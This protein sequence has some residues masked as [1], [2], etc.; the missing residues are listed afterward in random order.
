M[1]DS[2][3]DPGLALIGAYELTQTAFS[4]LG[5]DAVIGA[6]CSGAS[7]TAAEYLQI[8]KTPQLSPASTSAALSDSAAYPYLARTPPSDAWQSFALADVVE[9][10]LG[11]ERLATV[12][13][14]DTFGASGMQQFKTSATRRGLKVLASTSFAN[15]QEDLSSSVEVLRRSGA[16]VVVLFCQTEDASRFIQAMQAAGAHNIT[17]VGPGAVTLAVRAMV[18][19]SPEQ[20]ARLRGFVGTGQSGGEGE[21]Y[22]AFRARLNAFQATIFNEGW[23]SNATDDDGRLL[24]ATADGGCPWAGADASADFYAPFAYDAVYA[25]A[26]AMSRT[27]AAANA[28]LID[29]ETLLAQLLNLTFRGASGL[30]GFDEHGDRDVG[31]SY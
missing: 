6:S 23:C 12:N 8:Y 17:Y 20:E 15:F 14:D 30:V 19:D 9:H 11:V 13:S 25:M 18:N 28:T 22:T 21:A 27:L 4:G 3:C 16:L 2:A 10:L 31:I 26:H 24:W 5:A 29:G 7:M 1:K